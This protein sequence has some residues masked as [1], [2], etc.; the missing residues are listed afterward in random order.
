MDVHLINAKDL[1]EA[2]VAAAY[3]SEESRLEATKAAYELRILEF[4]AIPPSKTT[5]AM[6]Q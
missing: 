5:L 1:E 3:D 6:R 4:K 2:C